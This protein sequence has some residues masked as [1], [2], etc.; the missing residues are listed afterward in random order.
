VNRKIQ[1]GNIVLIR[2]PF[3]DLS[4]SKRRP[5]LILATYPPDVIV[6]FISSVAPTVP[7]LSDVLLQPSSPNFMSTGLK[8]TSVIRLRKLATLEQS[9][10]TRLLGRLDQSLLTAVDQ[11]LLEALEVDKE[12]IIRE[13]YQRLSVMLANQGET[14]VIAHIRSSRK[15]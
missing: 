15:N 2:F 9:L 8:K 5:A 7:E 10:I 6:A 3:T 11:A 4:S 14:A 13:E 1:R 12:L